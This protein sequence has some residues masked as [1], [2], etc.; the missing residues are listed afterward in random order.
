MPDEIP[1]ICARK[2]SQYNGYILW[3]NNPDGL[4]EVLVSA[5]DGETTSAY[6]TEFEAFEDKGPYAIFNQESSAI[7]YFLTDSDSEIGLFPGALFLW[8]VAYIV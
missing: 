8:E 6:I 2:S 4:G 5:S 1:L 3:K 7:T